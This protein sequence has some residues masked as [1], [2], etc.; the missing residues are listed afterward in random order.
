MPLPDDQ[1]ERLRNEL[2]GALRREPI[3][4]TRVDPDLLGGL[5]VQVG[6]W[7]Y[8]SSVR[9]R[10]ADIRNQLIERSSHEIQSRRNRFSA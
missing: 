5:V 8:D 6:D 9:S 1:L 7:V 10:V 3:L 4:E 2:R